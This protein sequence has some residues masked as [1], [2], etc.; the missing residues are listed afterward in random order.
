MGRFFPTTYIKW[1]EPRSI[2]RAVVSYETLAPSL[3][4]WLFIGFLLVFVG[5]AFLNWLLLRIHFGGPAPPLALVI[6]FGVEAAILVGYKAPQLVRCLL[7]FC[8]SVIVLTERGISR[9]I[10]NTAQ[11][12][13]YEEIGS[14]RIV[15][16][17]RGHLPPLS[18]LILTDQAGHESVIGI[19]GSLCRQELRRVLERQ[20]VSVVT[21]SVAETACHPA[22][23]FRS[24]L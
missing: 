1:T 17:A 14:C 10:G 24:L 12:W 6:L 21:E 9:V 13:R 7:R 4:R 8:P 19:D 20:G 22:E 18:V 23:Q 3:P 16:R 15:D 11:C 2:R 5:G